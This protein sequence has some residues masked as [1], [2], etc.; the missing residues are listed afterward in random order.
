[1]QVSATQNGTNTFK[2]NAPFQTTVLEGKIHSWLLLELEEEEGDYTIRYEQGERLSWMR[3]VGFAGRDQRE[4]STPL[5]WIL[6]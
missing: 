2:T 6:A 1:M 4:W 5:N 3:L